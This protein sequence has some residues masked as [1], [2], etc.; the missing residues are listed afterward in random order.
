MLSE[1]LNEVL[2]RVVSLAILP[3]A[4]QF[5]GFFIPQAESDCTEALHKVDRL[6][7]AEKE[8][9]TMTA[10]EFVIGDPGAKMVYMVKTD[11]TRKPLEQLREIQV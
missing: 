9:F 4:D 5:P 2:S 8:I 7:P 11:I 1:I 3:E 6:Y 10:F